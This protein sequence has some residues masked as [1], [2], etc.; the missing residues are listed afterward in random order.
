MN[1]L[2]KYEKV[3]K[4]E[5][6]DQLAD[7]IDSFADTDGKITGR[8]RRFDAKI[9]SDT[10]RRYTHMEHNRLTREYGIR[11]QALYILFYENTIN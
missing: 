4:C 7:V 2:E 10:C 8:S 11:Q 5:T 9:M 3:N 6:L 1:E